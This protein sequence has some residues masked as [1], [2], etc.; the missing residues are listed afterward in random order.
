[1]QKEANPARVDAGVASYRAMLYVLLCC[2]YTTA[3]N[4]P[5]SRRLLKS[6]CG[7]VVDFATCLPLTLH[8]QHELAGW[9]RI[10]P[11]SLLDIDTYRWPCPAPGAPGFKTQRDS[12]HRPIGCPAPNSGSIWHRPAIPPVQPQTKRCRTAPRT[13]GCSG[14][15]S[16]RCVLQQRCR[17]APGGRHRRGCTSSRGFR[18]WF[19]TLAA[20]CYGRLLGT[21]GFQVCAGCVVFSVELGAFVRHA[22]NVRQREH[23]L[24]RRVR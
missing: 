13:C 16:G 5:A 19:C 15:A 21:A 18:F 14:P 17:G 10:E 12:R 23:A 11:L 22:V 9:I 2:F 3:N 24:V 6:L 4:S 20:V 8:T 1:M 7:N